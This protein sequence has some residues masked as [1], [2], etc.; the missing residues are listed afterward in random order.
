MARTTAA[1]LA[2]RID[3]LEAALKTI[4]AQLKDAQAASS[5]ARPAAPALRKMI[6][7]CTTLGTSSADYALARSVAKERATGNTRFTYRI[8][9]CPDADRLRVV[10]HARAS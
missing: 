10:A 2:F 1:S 3:Q 9:R 4:E 8:E 5:A 7:V 6:L